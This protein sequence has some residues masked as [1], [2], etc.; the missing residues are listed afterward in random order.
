MNVIQWAELRTQALGIWDIGF[1]KVYCSLFG[2]I[3][4]AFIPT[5]VRAHLWW[6]VVPV[7]VLGIGL[8]IRW[9]TAPVRM[10]ADG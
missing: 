8:G 7:A 1:L 5:F 10:P 9:F 2:I 4:G 6:F 3:I